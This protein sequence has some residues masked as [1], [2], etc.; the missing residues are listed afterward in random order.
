MLNWTC[1]ACDAFNSPRQDTCWNCG[2]GRSATT[3]SARTPIKNTTPDATIT[4]AAPPRTSN[5]WTRLLQIF[6]IIGV[7]GAIAMIGSLFLPWVIRKA[8]DSE[9]EFIAGYTM[10]YGQITAVISL[11]LLFF[12]VRANLVRGWYFLAIIL[13][14]I[15]LIF[16]GAP[17]QVMQI[18]DMIAARIAGSETVATSISGV[19][20]TVVN[21]AAVL[22]IIAA[23]S[24]F[25]RPTKS[26]LSSD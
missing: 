6:R 11:I 2:N 14:L 13:A 18:D 12:M 1:A 16:S 23:F 10:I 15:L 3:T 21:W 5:F 22:I 25:F 4:A 8:P 9:I 24:Q 17:A 20:V 7:V 26:K 19:G